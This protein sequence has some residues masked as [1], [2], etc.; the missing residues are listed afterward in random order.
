MFAD[1]KI[2]ITTELMYEVYKEHA[3]HCPMIKMFERWCGKNLN[4]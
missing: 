3:N 4:Q 2:Q 1:N